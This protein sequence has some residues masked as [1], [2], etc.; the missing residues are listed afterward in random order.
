MIHNNTIIIMFKRV[1]FPSSFPLQIDASICCLI[2]TKRIKTRKYCIKNKHD[3]QHTL[4]I[5]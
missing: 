3:V 1:N 4:I 2:M 5:R